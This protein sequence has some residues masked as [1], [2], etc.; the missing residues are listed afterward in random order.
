MSEE[1]R[2]LKV[3]KNLYNAL[4]ELRETHGSTFLWI[5]AICIDQSNSQER[6]SQVCM[7][8]EIYTR[9]KSVVVWLGEN[10]SKVSAAMTVMSTIAERFHNDIQ[11]SPDSIVG[12]LGLRITAEDTERLESYVAEYTYAYGLVTQFFALPY[13][14]RLWV[15]QEVSSHPNVTIH[16]G[17][18][19]LPWSSVVLGALWQTRCIHSYTIYESLRSEET[20]ASGHLPEI[21]LA[22]LHTRPL[23]GLPIMELVCRA[24]EFKA[25]DPRDK[26]I[27]LLGLADDLED[28]ILQLEGL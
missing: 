19:T 28:S 18:R 27:A 4:K 8:Q 16:L 23:R 6:A 1:Y 5:D 11:H 10:T 21:W 12:P 9:A 24:R 22:L 17:P 7:M 26:V 3:T 14:R 15:V 2:P 13:F 25:S 20:D